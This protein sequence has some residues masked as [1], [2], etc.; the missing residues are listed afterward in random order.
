M[1]S[2][3]IIGIIV[4]QHC[5][6]LL[7]ISMMEEMNYSVKTCILCDCLKHKANTACAF[8]SN[9][10]LFLSKRI[11][12]IIS[13]ATTSVMVHQLNLK[14]TKFLSIYVTIFMIMASKLSGIFSHKP[15]QMPM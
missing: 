2:K 3:A 12:Q 1:Q 13:Y 8:I 10:M 7:F 9:I 4:K 14:S 15:W 6:L 11:F 5:T